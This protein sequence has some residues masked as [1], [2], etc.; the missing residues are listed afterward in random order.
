MRPNDRKYLKSHEWMKRDGDTALI[1]I[2]DFAVSQLSDL[3]FLDLPA[4]GDTVTAGETFGEIES[5]KAVSD[6]YSP[7][8]GEVLEVHADLPDNLD[9]LVDDPF[10][11]GWMLKIKVE[12]E[13]PDLLDASAY[14]KLV[15]SEG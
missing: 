1:G 12:G 6:L 14:E 15:E 9:L 8:T 7:V 3:T 11:K 10:E 2:S 13:S 4:V 5:V